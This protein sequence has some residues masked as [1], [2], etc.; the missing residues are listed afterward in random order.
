MK[1][2]GVALGGGALLIA[3]LHGM[4][5]EPNWPLLFGTGMIYLGNCITSTI[6]EGN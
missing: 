2:L 5:F 3:M 1:P 6:K 4:L